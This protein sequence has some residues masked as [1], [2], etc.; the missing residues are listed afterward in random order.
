MRLSLNS[1]VT[2][3]LVR[4]KR[5]EYAHMGDILAFWKV[6][7]S[8]V[9]AQPLAS[10][11]SQIVHASFASLKLVWKQFV[12]LM[13]LPVKSDPVQSASLISE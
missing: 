13:E 12:P 7:Q 6:A 5:Y 11:G 4:N 2:V 8:M 1:G 3:V 10:R 9:S